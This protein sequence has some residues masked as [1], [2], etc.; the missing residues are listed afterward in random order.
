MHV[1]VKCEWDINIYNQTSSTG[2]EVGA[3]ATLM[4]FQCLV[5]KVRH[6]LSSF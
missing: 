6:L 4:V 5:F 3:A 1:I 2:S